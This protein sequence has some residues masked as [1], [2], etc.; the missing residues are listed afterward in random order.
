MSTVFF[1]QYFSHFSEGPDALVN[2]GAIK[3][4]F[5]SE[6]FR[7]ASEKFCP[8]PMETFREM[9]AVTTHLPGI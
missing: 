1:Q 2:A 9:V 7:N 5:G 8:P 3:D 4:V 6:T